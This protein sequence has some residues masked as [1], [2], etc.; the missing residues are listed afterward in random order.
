MG[1]RLHM[2]AA[3]ALACWPMRRNRPSR[4]ER[5]YL[6]P[7]DDEADR[8]ALLDLA[9]FCYRYSP[10]IGFDDPTRPEGLLLEIGDSARLFGG[11]PALLHQAANDLAGKGYDVCLAL[12]DTPGAALGL[13]RAATP[14]HQG[15]QSVSETRCLC[16]VSVLPAADRPDGE[17]EIGRC[18]H[19]VI[20]TAGQGDE[21]T[22]ALPVWTLR[23][24]PEA[25]SLLQELGIHVIG[26]LRQLPRAGL[27]ARFGNDILRR[28][29]QMS[30]SR[31][32]PIVPLQPAEVIR[33][34]S[35]F[36]FAVSRHDILVH[37]CQRLLEP[38]TDRLERAGQGVQQLDLRLGCQPVTDAATGEAAASE[39]GFTLIL[40]QPRCSV[41]HLLEL[42][43]LKLER[44]PLPGPIERLEIAATIT[45]RLT[46]EQHELFA[47]G[48]H[49]G[50]LT[51]TG[52]LERLTGR[53]GREAVVAPRLV[54]D[55]QP[56][57]AFL[58]GPPCLPTR[59][60]VASRRRGRPVTPAIQTASSE[61]TLPGSVHAYRPLRLFNRPRPVLDPVYNDDG[62]LVEGRW[63]GRRHVIQRWH[64]PERVETGWWRG[65]AIG[66]DYYRVETTSGQRYW[67]FFHWSR[68]GWYSHGVFE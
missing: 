12:A 2:P 34:Q 44:L 16:F 9:R 14:E 52:L 18:H 42:I 31:P 50:G 57:E 64:G 61:T 65:P 4:A 15:R 24:S 20:A 51:L 17:Q 66:R 3:E 68:G 30:G 47:D 28:L 62:E 13:A 1:V 35:R 40:F 49:V 7:R 37:S 39:T 36:E 53:L 19:A 23:L 67:L 58:Y 41:P 21:A 59:T 56:E 26:Q 27:A 48:D 25:V 33:V 29:D 45:A 38:L 43:R 54:P 8:S 32:E 6:A 10:I 60:S 46:A 22:A 5:L 11:E 55:A 63:D